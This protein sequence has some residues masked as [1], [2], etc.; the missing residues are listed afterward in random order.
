[1]LDSRKNDQEL[2]EKVELGGS[3]IHRLP[4]DSRRQEGE[5]LSVAVVSKYS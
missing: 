1:M 3:V 4:V 5:L 2:E